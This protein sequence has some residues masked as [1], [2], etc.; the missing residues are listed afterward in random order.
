MQHDRNA[1]LAEGDEAAARCDEYESEDS[2]L[3]RAWDTQDE[4]LQSV[5]S[6][7]DAVRKMANNFRIMNE[8]AMNEMAITQQSKILQFNERAKEFQLEE[9]KRKAREAEWAQQLGDMAHKQSELA[10]VQQAMEQ[11]ER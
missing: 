10:R 7:A 9:V 11:K 5:Q 6:E 2:L 8:R 4:Y 1:V 3:N